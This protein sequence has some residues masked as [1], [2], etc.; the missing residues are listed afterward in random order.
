MYFNELK[1]LYGAD[2]AQDI[3]LFNNKE[4]LVEGKPLFIREWFNKGVISIQDLLNDFGCIMSYVEFKNKYSCQS[5][6]LQYY[7]VISAI[8][9]YLLTKAENNNPIIRS[10]EGL[11][12]ETSALYSLRWPIYIFNLVDITKLPI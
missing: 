10:D 11:T 7:Q 6:F 2:E 1:S 3:I 8:L 9:K 5:N 4:I 12:L